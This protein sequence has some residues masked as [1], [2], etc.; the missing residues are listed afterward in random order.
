MEEII[1]ESYSDKMDGFN[2]SINI[3]RR[4][5]DFILAVQQ[6]AKQKDISFSTLVINSLKVM[7]LDSGN[8]FKDFKEIY[9]KI[10]D[11]N[12][13]KTYVIYNGKKRKLKDL[14]E[15]EFIVDGV[16]KI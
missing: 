8:L 2:V 1:K 9:D 3:K 5:V 15:D 13:D 12:L 11:E 14:L 7:F 16:L 4:D 10:T 6:W